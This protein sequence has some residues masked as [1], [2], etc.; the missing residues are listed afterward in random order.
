MEKD[1]Y[2]SN[3]A[4]SPSSLGIPLKNCRSKNTAK[5]PPPKKE[6]RISGKKVLVKWNL[7]YRL[8]SGKSVTVLGIIIVERSRKKSGFINFDLILAKPNATKVLVN[9]VPTIDKKTTVNVLIK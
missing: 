4:D 3:S 1:F 5:A 8:Y 2:P 6:G 9:I 7:L